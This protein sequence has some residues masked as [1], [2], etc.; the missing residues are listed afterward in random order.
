[1]NGLKR[2][3]LYACR[4]IAASSMC[5]TC[6]AFAAPLPPGVPVLSTNPGKTAVRVTD[7]ARAIAFYRDTLGLPLLIDLGVTPNPPQLEIAM[8]LPERCRGGSSHAA[9]FGVPGTPGGTIELLQWIM[10][11]SCHLEK[12][13]PRIIPDIGGT[14]LLGWTV[15]DVPTAYDTLIARGVKFYGPPQVISAAGQSLMLAFFQDS[16]GTVMELV[17]PAPANWNENLS[18]SPFTKQ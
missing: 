11:R 10:P 9:A 15:A 6:S 14:F 2:T 1:M 12:Y 8:G 18:I 3:L 17:G 16:E 13:D 7:M 4:L 5:F